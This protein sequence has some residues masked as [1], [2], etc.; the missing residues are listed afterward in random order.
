M[1]ESVSAEPAGPVPVPAIPVVVP[2]SEGWPGM[3]GPVGFPFT[4]VS[5]GYP[6]GP[7][8]GPGSNPSENENF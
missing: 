4:G 3:E 5:L 8:S 7:G 6:G 1:P 2:T